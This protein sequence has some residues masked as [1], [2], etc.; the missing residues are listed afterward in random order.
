[1]KRSYNLFFP[2]IV[3]NYIFIVNYRL[4]PLGSKTDQTVLQFIPS[5]RFYL[6]VKLSSNKRKFI[7]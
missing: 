5:V 7:A 6:I 3:A 1:M 2:K 4:P